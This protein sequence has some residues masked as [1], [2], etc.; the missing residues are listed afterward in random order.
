MQRVL[1]CSTSSPVLDRPIPPLKPPPKKGLGGGGNKYYIKAT[2]RVV[3]RNNQKVAVDVW[4]T[5]K[6]ISIA[7]RVEATAKEKALAKYKAGTFDVTSPE[8]SFIADEEPEDM[9]T[10]YWIFF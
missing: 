6:S 10:V 7:K 5:S 8:C 9:E 4:G 3:L 1:L 2:C